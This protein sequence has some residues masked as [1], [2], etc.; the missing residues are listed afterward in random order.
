MSAPLIRTCP[1]CGLRFDSLP[2]L[3]LHIREDHRRR[4]RRAAPDDGDPAG[5]DAPDGRAGGG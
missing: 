2:I 1:L 4:E 3:E 5:P